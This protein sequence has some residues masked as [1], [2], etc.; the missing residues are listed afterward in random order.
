MKQTTE[1]K[2]V[3]IREIV[4][5]RQFQE[6]IAKNIQG[7]RNVRLI[8]PI[9]KPGYYYKR[10]SWDRLISEKK[11]TVNFFL[12]AIPAIWLKQSTLPSEQ[13]RVI[14]YICDKSVMEAF[15]SAKKL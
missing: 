14:Q 13:R 1:P 10:D 5:N 15:P 8:R 12:T 2:P 6:S 4:N 7:V 9:P 11:F 3:T